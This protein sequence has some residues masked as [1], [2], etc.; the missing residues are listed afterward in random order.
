MM[1]TPGSIKKES[2]LPSTPASVSASAQPTTRTSSRD[3]LLHLIENVL[4]QPED[5]SIHDSLT[6]EGAETLVDFLNFTDSEIDEYEVSDG[7][8]LPKKDK[9][10]LKNLLSFIKYIHKKNNQYQWMNLTPDDLHEFLSDIAPNMSRDS[11]DSKS[12]A[13]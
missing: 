2:K 11:H 10:K 12:S 1:S 9:K 8:K 13:V 6:Y 4:E 5:S 3:I 7:V